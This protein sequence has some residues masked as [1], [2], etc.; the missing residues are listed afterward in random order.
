MRRIITLIAAAILALAVIFTGATIAEAKAKPKV[1]HSK[2]VKAKAKAKAVAPT[3]AKCTFP[4]PKPQLI[5]P[6]WGTVLNYVTTRVIKD[7]RTDTR[8]WVNYRGPEVWLSNACGGEIH[9]MVYRYAS[10]PY[11][12]WM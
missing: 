7:Y 10:S 12:N 6:G 1:S 11:P 5:T 4:A 8:A 2:V 3:A 9:T